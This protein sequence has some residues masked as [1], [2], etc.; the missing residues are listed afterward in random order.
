MTEFHCTTYEDETPR[1]VA[2]IYIP[3]DLTSAAQI[4]SPSWPGGR[5]AGGTETQETVTARLPAPE[6]ATA[7]RISPT[8]PVLAIARIV[9]NSAGR[10]LEA[11][12]LALP[13]DAA[14]AVFTT[15][16]TLKEGET[17]R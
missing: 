14:D 9:L 2:R 5:D 10:V 15:H 16:P 6:E 11:A 13:S 12:L 4:A 3:R 1:S 7:L 17:E 8:R